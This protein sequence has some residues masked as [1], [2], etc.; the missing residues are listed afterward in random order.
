VPLP[1]HSPVRFAERFATLDRLSGGRL[2]WGV[3]RGVTATE[4]AGFGVAPA[5][6]RAL[7]LERLEALRTMLATGAM[8]RDGARYELHPAPRPQ[9][10]AGWMAA[11]SPESFELAAKLGLEVMSGPFKPWPL[12]RADLARYRRLRPEG[13]TAFALAAYCETDGAAARRRAEAGIVWV[14]RR[15][16]EIAAA[17]LERRTEGYEH[18]RHLGRLAPLLD[19]VLGLRSLELLGLAAV[20]DADH[21]GRRLAALARSGLD[22]A[23]LSIGGGDLDRAHAEACVARIGAEVLPRIAAGQATRAAR[24]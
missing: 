12:V 5:H 8:E 6:S 13:R 15:I 10:A 22:R 23:L 11:V 16:R 21:V 4:L 14:Y 24:A 1:P 2:L 20:G 18:Y 7:F 9:L 17:F 19:P 3:G